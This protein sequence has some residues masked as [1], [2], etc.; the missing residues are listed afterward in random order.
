MSEDTNQTDQ[1]ND[2]DNDGT[3]NGDG[4]DGNQDDAP[5]TFDEWLE[6]QAV[7]I[8]SLISEHTGGLKSAL[9]SERADRK[10]LQKQLRELTAQAEDGS[11]LRKQLDA[12][13]AEAD[14]ANRKATFYENAPGDLGN[15]R[16][17]WI[18]ANESDLVHKD[19]TAD[20][21][22]LKE[23]YPELFKKVVTATANAGSGAGQRTGARQPNM[24][25]AIRVMAGRPI[26]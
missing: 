18:A 19:G 13:N 8:K 10:K 3:S 1:V 7:P 26:T 11:E 6:A 12:L 15:P 9:D 23:Q 4:Q 21:V 25:D 24:N 2:T 5:Q 22:K 17:A 14:A 20:W 16:L